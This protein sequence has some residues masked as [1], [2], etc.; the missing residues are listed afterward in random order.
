[1]V[2]SAALVPRSPIGVILS[3]LK[4]RELWLNPFRQGP[5]AAFIRTALLFA[6]LKFRLDG[7]AHQLLAILA[8]WV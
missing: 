6:E 1:M 4:K 2:F 3:L 7:I 5:K 8:I